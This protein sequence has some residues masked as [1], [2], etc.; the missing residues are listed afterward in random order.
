VVCPG[1][2]DAYGDTRCGLKLRRRSGVRQ[3]VDAG[4]RITVFTATFN[5]ARQLH[6]VYD[7]LCQQTFRDFEWIVID[8]GSTDGTMDL[9]D[10]WKVSA[11]FPLRYFW[12]ENQGKHVAFNRAVSVAKGELFLAADS[13]DAFVPE[14]LEQFVFHW[15]SVPE[16]KRE[17]FVG[18]TALCVDDKGRVIGNRF[19]RSPMDSDALEIYYRHKVRGEKWG[20]H[21]VDVLRQYPFPE[22]PGGKFVPEEIVWGAI[23]ESFRTRFVNEPLRIYFGDCNDQITKWSPGRV[24]EART[25]YAEIISRAMRW[26]RFSPV[27]LCRWMIHYVRFSVLQGDAARVQVRRLP[28]RSAKI[29]WAICFSVG[30]TVA[31]RDVLLGKD[32]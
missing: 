23:G 3:D 6:R 29:L 1:Q 16:S 13:D 12:Q 8:D 21:R 27:E 14:A 30:Y 4:C 20:F 19:P 15:E 5:R 10:E 11:K 28:S 25:Y 17:E 26:I 22:P 7:S 31:K 18:V 32:M 9:V 2:T 24:S